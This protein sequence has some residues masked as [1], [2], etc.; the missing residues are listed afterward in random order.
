MATHGELRRRY[1]ETPR[2]IDG[3]LVDLAKGERGCL[4]DG[5]IALG[6]LLIALFGF[7]GLFFGVGQGYALVGA[8]LFIAGF[9]LSTRAQA[10][11][12]RV[13][14]AA[15]TSGPL[16]RGQVV[17][18]RPD[19]WERESVTGPAAVVF[20]VEPRGRFD[21][22][23]LERVAARLRAL[24]QAEGL[25]PEQEDVARQ[26]RREL[27]E[28]VI[29]LPDSLVGEDAPSVY[30]ATVIVD[31]HRLPAG[32]LTDGALTLIVEPSVEFVEHV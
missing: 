8:G 7:V 20:S 27:I 31:T 28:R 15:L 26:L 14:R 23:L 9:L 13:R 24:E 32:R 2:T 6:V 29:A 19:L 25:P 4:G 1:E 5:L 21:G 17:K 16:V 22:A 10:I 30:L 3:E 18:G 11:S 12:T